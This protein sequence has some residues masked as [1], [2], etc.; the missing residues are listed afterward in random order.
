MLNRNAPS[1]TSYYL[2]FLTRHGQGY[3]NLAESYYS[4]DAWDCYYAALDGDPKS[5]ITWADA[6]LSNLGKRQAREFARFW[7]KQHAEQGTPTPKAWFVSPLDRAIQTADILIDGVLGRASRIRQP[8]IKEKLREENGI[9]TCDRRSTRGEIEKRWGD[10]FA[11]EQDLTEKDELWQSDV[12]E[13]KEAHSRRAT[14][15]LDE[16]FG[17]AE[18][19]VYLAM[20]AHGGAVNAILRAVGHREFQLSTGSGMPLLLKIERLEGKRPDGGQL[21]PGK[22]APACV[23]D[24]LK[25]GLPGYKNFEDFVNASENGD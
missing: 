25:A 12:R 4:T 22:G 20:T 21:E 17:E 14:L 18:V 8:L 19:P 24:P 10:K 23:S 15:L 16:V 2:L 6:H 9:H 7:K 11:I 1:G 3:H 13:T 5:S